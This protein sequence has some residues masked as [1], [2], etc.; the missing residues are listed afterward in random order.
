MVGTGEGAP[1]D[2]HILVGGA[3]ALKLLVLAAEKFAEAQH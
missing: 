3:H 1:R 2:A